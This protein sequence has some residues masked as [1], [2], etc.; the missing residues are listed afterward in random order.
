MARPIDE[1][2]RQLSARTTADVRVTRLQRPARRPLGPATAPLAPPS[3][4]FMAEHGEIGIAIEESEFVALVMGGAK[5]TKF[6]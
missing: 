2:L 1:M 3:D 6:A 5:E 4:T